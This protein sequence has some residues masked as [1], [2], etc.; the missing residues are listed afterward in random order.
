M[1]KKE[2]FEDRKKT[3]QS[4]YFQTP[5]FP[6]QVKKRTV[7]WLWNREKSFVG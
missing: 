2:S 7:T 6:G 4:L 5:P 3:I 1:E